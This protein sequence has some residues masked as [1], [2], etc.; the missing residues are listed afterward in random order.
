MART[1]TEADIQEFPVTETV[2]KNT[3]ELAIS[4]DANDMANAV[5]LEAEEAFKI[6]GHIEAAQFMLTVSEKMMAESAIKIK[7]G[8]L[9][10][11]LLITDENGIRRHVSNFDEFCKF[12]LKKSR[13]RVEELVRNYNM[14]G[15]DLYEQAEQLGFTQRDYNALK[16]LPADDRAL[17]AQAIEEEN[18]DKALDIMQEMAA[19]HVREKELI[20]TRLAEQ[21]LSLE[22]KDRVIRDKTEELNKKAEKLAALEHVKSQPISADQALIDARSNLQI[23]AVNLKMEVASRM[24]Q[25]I[26]ALMALD[27]AQRQYAAALVIEVKTELD[28]LIGDF[29]LP[30]AIDDNPVPEWMRGTEFDPHKAEA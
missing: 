26:K 11:S 14:L 8:K 3:Q 24:M 21:S 7:K 23:T 28:I 27:P 16:A 4:L 15:P 29:G 13:Q 10:K 30:S 1:K 9:F 17:I 18:L 12:K 25:Q 19:K 2:E 22:A 6:I 20:N 5:I